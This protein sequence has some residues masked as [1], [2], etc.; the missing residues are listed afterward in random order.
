MLS[1]FRSRTRSSG[2]RR[3]G[4]QALYTFGRGSRSIKRSI[5]ERAKRTG[6][7]TL[8]LRQKPDEHGISFEFIVN[9]IPFSAAAQLDTGRQFTTRITKEKYRKL[10]T[11]LR[12]ANMNMVRVWGG[13]IYED[14]YYYDLADEMGMLVWQDFMF[15]CSMYPGDKAFLDNVRHEAID[16]VKRLRN[17]PTIVIWVGNNEIETAWQHWGGGRTR[18]RASSGKIIKK[19]SYVFCRR[20]EQYDPSRPYWQS[21]PSSNFQAD[22]EF[23]ASATC[24]TG[25][26]G[27]LE[28]PFTEYEKQYPAFHERIRFSVVSRISKRSRPTRPKRTAN[29]RNADNARAPAA[30]ARQPARPH[31]HAARV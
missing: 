2:A 5:D 12:D 27:T 18:T 30:S 24:I 28:K 10:L 8:E 20:F 15:A 26:S 3:L 7:R 6:L 4:D 21:S 11:S 16:N 1:I 14:D 25:R 13:G 19:F 17:H 9:G 31:I 22:S 23:R 29:H